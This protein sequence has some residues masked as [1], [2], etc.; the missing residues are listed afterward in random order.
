MIVTPTINYNGRVPVIKIDP[1]GSHIEVIIEI[2]YK[3]P[4]NPEIDAAL[5]I[6]KASGNIMFEVGN[7]FKLYG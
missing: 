6:A 4:L 7:D 1:S 5:V 3:N 2:H